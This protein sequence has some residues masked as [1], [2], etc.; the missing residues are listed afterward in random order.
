MTNVNRI[1][2]YNSIICECFCNGFIDFMLKGKK[3]QKIY[4]VDFGSTE[5]LKTLKYHVFSK[6][7]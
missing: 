7:H 4:C 6:K 5:N 3:W 2:A 1:Q